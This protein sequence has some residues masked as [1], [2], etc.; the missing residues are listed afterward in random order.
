VRTPRTR[1][2]VLLRAALD[3]VLLD[4]KAADAREIDWLV[5]RTAARPERVEILRVSPSLEHVDPGGIH[6][7]GR[8]REVQAPWCLAGE[9]YGTST[10]RNLGVSVSWI[11]DEVT[12]DDEH[13]PIVATS[14]CRERCHAQVRWMAY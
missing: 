10:C 14:R 13:L 12:G 4:L 5:I 6:G 1:V 3:A 7:I 2:R 9:P 8:D 11:E